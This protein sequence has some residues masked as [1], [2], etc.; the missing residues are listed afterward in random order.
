MGRFDHIVE[1]VVEDLEKKENDKRPSMPWYGRDWLNDDALQLCSWKAK[2]IAA[3]FFSH[4][5]CCSPVAGVFLQSNGD[6]PSLEE[7]AKI[8]R[9]QPEDA[10]DALEELHRRDVVK[11]TPDGVFYSAKQVR[12]ARKS[13]ANSVNARSR[14]DK[15]S[16]SKSANQ[17]VSDV[18]ICETDAKRNALSGYGEG[19]SSSYSS[20]EEGVQREEGKA[21]TPVV[22]K[23]PPVDVVVERYRKH[24]SKARPGEKVRRRI[25]DRFKEGFSVED[26]CRAIEGC[27]VSPWHC[28]ENP[29]GTL[30]QS[31]DL[32]VRDSEH[33]HSF[34]EK[35]DQFERG[36]LRPRSA[37]PL[38]AA[39]ANVQRLLE[40]A[41][42]QPKLFPDDTSAEL[43][44]IATGA[45]RI[46]NRSSELRVRARGE[47]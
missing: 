17:D 36:D 16:K 18:R 32:I 46:M 5:G 4:T 24:H 47:A 26:L 11:R 13:E 25:R 37:G 15:R 2:A 30:Y 8:L 27:H 35:F 34:I 6:K 41:T 3:N 9:C 14:W 31:L 39:E 1:A 40:V 29:D 45:L 19:T 44:A 28:G 21:L 23:T 42:P 22:P 10:K 12:M 33:V 38:T 20:S 43:D 7:T